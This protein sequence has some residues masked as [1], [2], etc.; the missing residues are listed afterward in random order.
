MGTRGK[1]VKVLYIEDDAGLARLL[2]RR[3][4]RSGM[5]V[6]VA[7]G[8][9]NGLTINDEWR[10]N[11]IALDYNLPDING[12]EVLRRLNDATTPCPPVIFI[13][14][15]GDENVAVEAMHLGAGD[16]LVKDAGGRYLEILPR[17]IDRVLAHRFLQDEKRKT[18]EDLRRSQKRLQEAQRIARLGNWEWDIINDVIQTSE[19]VPKIL[20]L[21]GGTPLSNF[22]QFRSTVHAADREKLTRTVNSALADNDAYRIDYRVQCLTG[23]IRHLQE[24]CEVRVG[25]SGDPIRLVGTL[26]DITESKMAEETLQYRLLQEK[27]VSN[28]STRFVNRDLDIDSAISETLT[29]IGTLC[30]VSRAYLFLFRDGEETMDNTHE[31]C[32]EGVNAEIDQLQDMPV[33]AYPWL[34][35]RVL[36]NQ[37]VVISDISRLPPEAALEKKTLERQQIK[38]ALI[39]PVKIGGKVR[40]FLGLDNTK[41]AATWNP[42]DIILLRVSSEIIGNAIKSSRDEEALFAEKERVQITLHSIGDAV[43]T[44][45][46]EGRI[47]YLNPIAEAMTGWPLDEALNRPL[48]TVFRIVNEAT[49]EPAS[50]PVARCPEQNKIVGLANHTIL[51]SRSGLEYAIQDSAAPIRDRSGSVIGVVLV[52]SDVTEA[53]R[54]ALQISHQATHD[55]LTGLV[56]RHELNR[57]L[58]R[59]CASAR[60]H[61]TSHALCYLDLDQF[62]VVND[63]AS[64]AAGDELLKQI[65][66]L[67]S[68]K[69][70]GRDTLARLGGDEFCVL[71]E[72]CPVDKACQ[73]AEGLVTAVNHFRFSWEQKIFRIGLSIGLTIIDG[74]SA[75]PQQL[76]TEADVA[77]YTAKD[78][79][80]NRVHIY[81]ADEQGLP[82][83]HAEMF[84]VAELREALKESRFRLYY[85]PIVALGKNRD[86]LVHYEVLL[87]LIDPTGKIVM[88]GAFIPA[89]ERFGLMEDIDRWVIATAFDQYPSIGAAN[90]QVSISIN[91]SGDTINNHANL[92]FICN[93]LVESGIQPQRVCFE[94]TETAAIQNFT[95]ASQFIAELKQTGC[96]FALDDFGSGLSSFAYLRK[97]PVDFLKIDGNFVKDIVGDLVNRAMVEAINQVGHIMDIETIA[98]YTEND[99][100]LALLRNMGVDYAQGYALGKPMVFTFYCDDVDD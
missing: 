76:L 31:W 21:A 44:T 82:R 2:Q 75:N 4:E 46:A 62:K 9:R 15:A 14:G 17:V 72:N 83:R 48:K 13:T 50:D 25:E 92:D 7:P 24:Q 38:A 91:L 30:G 49:R 58:Q 34:M 45:D 56:N 27:V 29:E 84:R 61:A 54:L 96:R 59:A 40:G 87:R 47:N 18:E 19:I 60:D 6:R 10:P 80:R 39:L 22:S 77:C 53:R 65:T 73:V 78:L 5:E 70:R 1:P 20:G 63:T 79:G 3:L 69:L 97:L 28:I 26:Q 16:Y 100:I 98:E 67:L 42:N 12:I 95:Q 8:G 68:Q 57:R 85:Q 99:S 55:A 35:Q 94:I 89:A 37:T 90:Q 43:I 71:L 86:S 52:F 41:T 74:D 88:P 81:R 36:G 66:G 11:L 93:K 23:E 32:V 64:H 51:I 33:N